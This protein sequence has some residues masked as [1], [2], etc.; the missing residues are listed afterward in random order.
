MTDEGTFWGRL[1]P[2]AQAAGALATIEDPKTVVRLVLLTVVGAAASTAGFAVLFFFFDEPV[3]GWSTLA[4]ATAFALTAGWYVLGRS[5]G[6]VVIAVSLVTVIAATNHITVHL[7][8]GGYANSGA[9][10]FWGIAVLMTSSLTLSRKAI[11][12]ATAFYLIT[13]IV[14]GFLEDTLAASRPPPDPTLTTILFVIVFSGNLMQLIPM[15]AYF[16]E[17]LSTE[18]ARAEALLLN[19][20]PAEVATELKEH[21]ETK[22]QRFEAISVLFADAVGFTPTTADMDPTE[23]VDMLN[24][25]FSHFD[26]LAEKYDCEKIRTI[27]DAYMVA[28][29]IPV[30]RADHAAAL[31]AMALEMLEYGNRSPLRFRVGINSGPA[32]AGVIGLKKFQYDVWGDTV[33]TASRMES[34]GEPGKIQITEATYRLIKDDFVCTP[35]G[36]LEVKGKGTLDTWYLEGARELAPTGV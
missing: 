13:G 8:L 31:A 35:H 10:L 1:A 17:R 4:L 7:A 16:L 23:V 18:R 28:S 30:P 3:A 33:N 14:L 21:G 11:I 36:P 19:V 2:R 5:S 34:Q 32:V 6:K 15:F 29:G 22:A 25:V 9:Y 12:G 26:A 27:G 20:L 24:E